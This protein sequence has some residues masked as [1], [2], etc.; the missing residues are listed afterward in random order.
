MKD[1]THGQQADDSKRERMIDIVRDIRNLAECYHDAW[2]ND[3]VEFCDNEIIV[4]E[5]CSI[6]DRIEATIK[7]ETK[8]LRMEAASAKEDRNRVAVR[9]REEF[10]AKCKE[11]KAAHSRE[12]DDALNMGAL[13]VAKDMPGNT[14]AM[15]VV[16]RA[17]SDWLLK[18]FGSAP[19]DPDHDKAKELYFAATGVCV[20]P[21]RNCD[22]FTNLDEARNAFYQIYFG[23]TEPE[24]LDDA[25]E[26]WLF[27]KADD[28]APTDGSVGGQV[29]GAR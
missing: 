24:F 6:A 1:E 21:A 9:M 26:K 16:L 10:S 15:R 2:L 29:G 3:P 7:R 14:A 25:F 18:R 28:G 22:R 20:A 12:V 11:C 23:P 27:D 13:A 17:V 4:H 19:N 8:E 5:L